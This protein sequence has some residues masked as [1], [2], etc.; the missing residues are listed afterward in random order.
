M[1]YNVKI[2]WQKKSN[3]IFIDK[4]YSRAHKW[5]FDCGIE[6]RAS[7]SPHI[8]PVPLSDESAI[9]P[10]EAFL[11]AI[12]CCHMLSFL[13][14]AASKKYIVES[15]EDSAEGILS[16]NGRGKM[17]MTEVNLKPKI[18]FSGD[19]IPSQTQIDEF[20]HLAHEECFIASSVKT[21]IN[22]IS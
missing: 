8:V 14:I 6:I 5:I 22:I 20:H 16:K 15:Y 12:S 7:S 10:E 21:K 2:L 19:K 9:D 1:L 13:P 3:E 4:K 18:I 17:A 11:A